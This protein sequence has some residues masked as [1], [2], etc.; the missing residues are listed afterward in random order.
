MKISQ[1][2]RLLLWNRS[3]APFN[4]LANL[5]P[6]S[7]DEEDTVL[8]PTQAPTQVIEVGRNRRRT[9]TPESPDKR[10]YWSSTSTNANQRDRTQARLRRNWNPPR[11]P[12][13]VDIDT[14]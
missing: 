11:V 8:P 2:E 5:K 14:I 12:G 10:K 9:K 13:R 4:L 6:I 1:P 3:E 7:D